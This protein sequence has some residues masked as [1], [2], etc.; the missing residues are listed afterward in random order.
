MSETTP[1]LDSQSGLGSLS[2]LVSPIASHLTALDRFLETELGVFEVEL[3]PLIAHSLKNSGKRLRPILVFFAGY[4]PQ[5]S[6]AIP[7]VRAAAIVELV[8]LATLVH[9]DILD[10]ARLRHRM[11][12]LNTTHN[13]HVAVLTGDALFAHA[14]KLTADFPTVEVC[15]IVASATRM[16][17]AGEVGQTFA[18]GDFDYT[19]EAYYRAIDLKTAELFRVS[20]YLGAMVSGHPQDYQDA[21][22]RFARELGLA[23][24]IYD[25]LID[26]MDD[27]EK[28]GKTLGTDWC[29]GKCTLPLILLR[30]KLSPEAFTAFQTRV[31]QGKVSLDDLRKM[32]IQYAILPDVLE[33]FESHLEQ[34]L[35][36]LLPYMEKML[37]APKLLLLN[38]FIRSKVNAFARS[39]AN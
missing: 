11:V 37:G 26:V 3:R 36:F 1:K 30:E 28:A 9:D 19:R 8:H 35:R 39:L 14:L 25:D 20:A 2:E 24:Q 17:C 13:N 6:P 5:P 15:R 7:L 21:V 34:G 4:D 22:A 18:R 12:T 29:S 38:D 23:Y 27:E 31:R 32:L 16:I 10:E 33:V